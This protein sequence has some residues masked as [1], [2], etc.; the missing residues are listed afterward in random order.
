VPVVA[1]TAHREPLYSMN[2]Q[3]T[4]LNA[5]VAKPIDFDWPGELLRSLVTG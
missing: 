5:F 2:A 1:V 3:G 4:G